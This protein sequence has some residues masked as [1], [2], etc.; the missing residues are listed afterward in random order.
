MLPDTL[1][2][3]DPIWGCYTGKMKKIVAFVS[4][5]PPVK[6]AWAE[7]IAI[8]DSYPST[9]GKF[10]TALRRLSRLSEQGDAGSGSATPA[11]EDVTSS[12][13]T[14]TPEHVLEDASHDNVMTRPSSG[15]FVVFSFGSTDTDI[16]TSPQVAPPATSGS[17][18]V[19]VPVAKTAGD[20]H[21]SPGSRSAA[22][23]LSATPNQDSS[24]NDF[25]ESQT[26]DSASAQNV[27]HD[28]GFLD[29]ININS[30]QHVCMVSELRLRYEHEIITREKFKKKFIDSAALVQQRDAKIADLR[31]R[32]EKSE[33]EA[34]EVTKLHKRMSDL[35]ATV[36]VRDGELANLHTENVGLAGKVF[37]LE[38]EGDGL[39]N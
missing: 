6:K 1:F 12:S 31:V 17:A 3:C 29:A 9:A 33:A 5:P 37:A 8:F 13:V 35:E 23:D 36:A 11:M 39:K 38:L 22:G 18:G 27:Y 32:L 10:P 4:E 7:G 25:Y 20:S 26:I 21:R 16:P 19:N 30:A 34:A 15:H 24:A 14:P 2:H 28:V